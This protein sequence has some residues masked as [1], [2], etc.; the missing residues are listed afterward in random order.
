MLRRA[1]AYET[2]TRTLKA[3]DGYLS[4]VEAYEYGVMGGSGHGKDCPTPAKL[5]RKTLKDFPPSL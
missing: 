4:G 2:L 3:L 1:N 5:V